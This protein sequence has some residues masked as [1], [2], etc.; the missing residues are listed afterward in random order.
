[1][2]KKQTIIRNPIAFDVSNLF[3]TVAI[4]CLFV[5]CGLLFMAQPLAAQQGFTLR[6]IALDKDTTFLQ[7]RFPFQTQ[8]RTKTAVENELKNILTKLHDKFWLAA[9]LDSLVRTDSTYFAYFHIGNQIEWAALENGNIDPNVL[10]AIG[11]NAKFYKKKSLDIKTIERLKQKILG[12][13]EN[14]GYP[15][16]RV[17]L[18]DVVWLGG[19]VAAK[20][21]WEKKR[22]ITFDELQLEGETV[23]SKAYLSNYLGVKKG[24]LYSE[25]TV[26]EIR[27][28]LNALPFVKEKQGFM[29]IFSGDVAKVVLFLEKRNASRFDFIVGVLPR[30]DITGRPV[31]TGSLQADLKNPFGTGKSIGVDW[32]RLKAETSRLKV[33]AAYPYVLNLPFGLEGNLDI[34]R[35]DTSLQDTKLNVGVQYLFQGNN[36]LKI[37]WKSTANNLLSVNTAQVIVS[38]ELPGTLDVVNTQLGLAYVFQRLNN[39]IN[40]QKGFSVSLQ[41][42]AGIKQIRK[43]NA[44][45]TLSDEAQPSFDFATLYDSLTLR[46]FQIST[47]AELAY[48]QPLGKRATIK[49]ALSGGFLYT[50]TPLY[51]NELYRIGGNR[52]L[53]GFDE[54]SV[55]ASTYALLTLEPR[56][57]L[58]ETSYLF[59]FLDY[60]YIEDKSIGNERTD[61]PL[62]FGLGLSLGT[63]AGIVRMSYAIGRQLENPVDFRAA[64]IHFGYVNY[65]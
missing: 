4:R 22:L 52:L 44:I 57:L 50:K 45:L 19:K 59:G 30:N 15:F 14:N 33:Y 28:R 37:F 10:E 20:W 2:I 63:P 31:I 21:Y 13:A 23:L 8:H 16:A 38:K 41:T 24:D 5:V 42:G 62:G 56:F 11:F 35:R 65:F 53:R 9:S 27:N 39:P 58:N 61:F 3:Q 54:E 55:L 17:W 25:K 51:Q 36:A 18:G 6:A 40:P 26:K 49:G 48:Y 32:Q 64:K 34:Y 46:A 29:V 47:E 60:A 43:N 7:T 1:M 12:Y